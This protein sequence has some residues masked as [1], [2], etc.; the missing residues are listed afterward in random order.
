MDEVL[1]LPSNYISQCIKGSTKKAMNERI[2]GWISDIMKLDPNNETTDEVVNFLML[3]RN[4]IAE[5]KFTE[6]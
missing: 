5:D 4:D 1:K 2:C 3:L 6:R